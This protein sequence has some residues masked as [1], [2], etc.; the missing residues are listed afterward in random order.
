ML[1]YWVKEF[2]PGRVSIDLFNDLV[3]RRCRV[4]DFRDGQGNLIDRRG[5]LKE[6][7]PLTPAP[8]PSPTISMTDLD[9][10]L[11]AMMK[12]KAV[13]IMEEQEPKKEERE[14]QRQCVCQIAIDQ[15]QERIEERQERRAR[16]RRATTI[17]Y[18]LLKARPRAH[19]YIP[20]ADEGVPPPSSPVQMPLQQVTVNFVQ[21]AAR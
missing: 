18:E 12:L 21:W 5:A 7:D 2:H 20:G 14:G 6:G 17:D 15:E 4:V 9:D 10:P 3:K 19:T 13:E 11:K 1:E 16:K 8:I